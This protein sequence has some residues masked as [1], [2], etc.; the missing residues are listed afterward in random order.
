VW[1]QIAPFVILGSLASRAAPADEQPICADRPGKA[2][3]TCTVP[4]GM[5]QLETGL[6]DWSRDSSAGA[7]S[8]AVVIASTAI[9]YGLSDRWHV[10]LDVAPYESLRVHGASLAARDSGLGD[11]FV[12]SKYRMTPRHGVQVALSPF[13]KVPTAKHPIGNGRWEAGVAVPI[14]VAIAR[15]PLSITLGPEL[16]WLADDDGSGHHA[17]MVQVAALG[18]Q[19][20]D[21]LSLSGELWSQW[22]WDPA[23][24]TRQATADA[25]FACL[26][27]NDLQLDAGA[28]FGLNRQSPDVEVYSG[29]SLRF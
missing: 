7:R 14:D 28:N 3:P 21:K 17:A 23:G 2:N 26:V 16:D 8:E 20:T 22:N 1:K 29:V 15:S 18:W 6:I 11:L 5:V 9:K 13:V 12:R 4:K 10:E 24:T 25:A 27:S 19:L